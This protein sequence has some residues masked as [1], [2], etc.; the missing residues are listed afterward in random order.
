MTPPVGSAAEEAIKSRGGKSPGSVSKKT[1]AVVV[2][3]DPG[4]SKLNKAVELGIPVLDATAFAHLLET[5]ETGS[6]SQ[7]ESEDGEG[8]LVGEGCA[9]VLGQPPVDHLHGVD[10]LGQ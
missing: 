6:P 1:Y 4:V 2:G 3:E 10:P 8:P 7:D 9:A 5:G